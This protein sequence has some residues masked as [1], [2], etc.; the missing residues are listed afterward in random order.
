MPAPDLNRPPQL[1]AAELRWVVA[2]SVP[3][4]ITWGSVFYG[5]ALFLQPMEAALGTSRADM[6]LAF[7]LALLAEGLLA[8]AVGRA[9]DRGHARAVMTAG[10]LGVAGGLLALSQAHHLTA[11]YACWTLL[12]VALAATLYAPAFVVLIQ[13]FDQRYRQAIIVLTLLGGLASTVFI[14]VVDI[15]IDRLGWQQALW[16]LA[17]LQLGVCA[18]LHARLLRA[19][20]KPHSAIHSIAESAVN[21]GDR[22][23][24]ATSSRGPD[25]APALAPLLRRPPFIGLAVF[26]VALMGVTAALP[27]HLVSL[28][29]ESGLGEA[30]AIWIP[31]SIGVLQVLGRLA[32]WALEQRVDVHRANVAVA[33]LVPAGLAV[34]S[35]GM[36]QPVAALA[37]VLLYGLGNGMLTIVKGTAMALYV[38]REHAGALNGV[39]GVP[40]A[41]A[42]AALPWAVGAMYTAPSASSTQGGYWLGLCLLL[43]VSL[44]GLGGLVLAV[45]AAHRA[46]VGV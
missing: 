2:F 31:A 16:V 23:G 7:S 35:A 38:S 13:R 37:F 17:A 8:F 32:L 21:K 44:L 28:L 22:G 33:A 18:P 29:R 43:G 25:G 45:R 15:L 19:S 1:S 30:W 36:G 42:R 41:L 24:L 3:Q 12:G 20:D 4:L 39:L 10:S 14:P 40:Q 5:F 46:P 6:S 26:T 34:L 11:L 27:A 9:I